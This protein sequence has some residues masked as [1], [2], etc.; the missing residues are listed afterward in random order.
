MPENIIPYYKRVVGGGAAPG[1]GNNNVRTRIKT[2]GRE[3]SRG[4]GVTRGY[5]TGV[6]PV[7]IHTAVSRAASKT[8][9]RSIMRTGTNFANFPGSSGGTKNRGIR[10]IILLA[11]PP[12][13]H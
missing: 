4:D 9:P 5:Y 6:V 1:A 7:R 12:A 2:T 8:P 13:R 11:F 3:G 10:T